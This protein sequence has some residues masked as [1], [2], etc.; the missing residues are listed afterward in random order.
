MMVILMRSA[1]PYYGALDSAAMSDGVARVLLCVLPLTGMG[2]A[3]VG[4]TV[5]NEMASV[6][7]V[8][9]EEYNVPL[10]VRE[11]A[12]RPLRSL[13]GVAEP[14]V[15][16]AVVPRRG[17]QHGGGGRRQRSERRA[18][19]SRRGRGRPFGVSWH[20]P[21]LPPPHHIHS[22]STVSVAVAASPATPAQAA[23]VSVDVCFLALGKPTQI[24]MSVSIIRNIEAQSTNSTVHFHLLVDKSPTELRREMRQREVWRGLPTDRVHLHT[25]A[26]IPRRAKDLYRRLSRSATGP[27]PIYLYKPLLHLVLPEHLSRV[28]VLDTDLF[29][30][31]D[32]LGLWREFDAF[33]PGELLGVAAEQC[34]SY[35]EASP[36]LSTECLQLPPPS[37]E[38][39]QLAIRSDLPASRAIERPRLRRR[40][41]EHPP[42]PCCRR[43]LP[44]AR[45]PSLADSRARRLPRS[46]RCAPLA[47]WASTAAC[48]FST[49]PRCARRATTPS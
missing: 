33:Q 34:P 32:V 24:D 23:R 49:W 30:F 47:A 28:I 31:E 1:L 4:L 8:Q 36:S 26:E 16:V 2:V 41:R 43:L 20:P 48:S 5:A 25:V 40:A 19:R 35:Q 14:A 3:F 44:A 7:I 11:A 46:R 22:S 29:L 38:R 6:S 42:R 27:G 13:E 15:A 12:R 37:R 39:V 18:H 21:P 17:E 9:Q 45:P 10:V